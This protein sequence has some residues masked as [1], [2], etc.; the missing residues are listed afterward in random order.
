[1]EGD[2]AC[3]AVCDLYMTSRYRMLNMLKYLNTIGK[4]KEKF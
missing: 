2:D 4:Q 3:N 1:M